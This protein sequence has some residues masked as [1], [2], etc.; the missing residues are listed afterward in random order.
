MRKRWA[1]VGVVLIG[2]AGIGICVWLALHGPLRFGLGTEAQRPEGDARSVQVAPPD[3]AVEGV[4]EARAS[5]VEESGPRASV[6]PPVGSLQLTCATTCGPPP[7][8]WPELEI[9]RAEDPGVLRRSAA[10]FV[11]WEDLRTGTWILEV[12]GVPWMPARTTIEISGGRPLEHRLELTPW[13][14]YRGALMDSQTLAAIESAEVL[15]AWRPKDGPRDSEVSWVPVALTCPGGKFCLTGPPEAAESVQFRFSAE[16][17][18]RASTDWL[19]AAPG[20]HIEDLVVLL[21][22]QTLARLG[23]VVR[24]GV[25]MTPIDG[26]VLCAVDARFT[27]EQVFVSDGDIYFAGMEEGF[28]ELT[29]SGRTTESAAQGAWSIDVETPGSLRVL[30]IAAG[31]R[32]WLSETQDLAS[33]LT[34]LALD[35]FL[36]KGGTLR[37]RV[38][39]DGAPE[40]PLPAAVELRPLDGRSSLSSTVGA[41]L[42]FEFDGLDPGRFTAVVYGDPPGAAG[43]LPTVMLA[44]QDVEVRAGL[45]TEVEIPCGSLRP[46]RSLLGR[47]QLPAGV[48]IHVAIGA[49]CTA[50]GLGD[51]CASAIVGPDGSFALHGIPVDV[52][53]LAVVA[54]GMSV[55]RRDRVF[56]LVEVDLG[57]PGGESLSIDVSRGTIEIECGASS[58]LQRGERL[59]IVPE[60]GSAAHPW[61]GALFERSSCARLEFA[62]GARYRLF[63]LPAGEYRLQGEGYDEPFAVGIEPGYLLID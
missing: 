26:V 20:A 16:G 49:V 41:D 9:Q 42:A 31:Y 14:S 63:G 12:A 19:P 38:L 59:R 32:V 60:A 55:E 46:G 8:G 39:T 44:S 1:R 21:D 61:L 13:S 22:S 7:F 6:D 18:R 54:D 35:V 58:Q 40:S 53:H 4:D 45:L 10:P 28:A 51:P 57:V 47:V 24:D 17:H 11:H 15:A 34:E 33:G 30:A 5:R 50:P 37:G 36:E 25:T 23:G 56:T 27:R 2:S 29:E 52:Q 3:P 48:E 62:P 43:K